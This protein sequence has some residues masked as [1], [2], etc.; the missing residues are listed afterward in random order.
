MTIAFDATST[1]TAASTTLTV[2][3]TCSGSDR[4][5]VVGVVG[6]TADE[7]T[8]VTYNGVAMT[9]I[10]KKAET[11]SRYVYLYYLNAPATG[12]HDIVVSA[13]GSAYLELSAASYTGVLQTGQPEVNAVNS[14]VS[15][16]SLTTSLTTLADNA[17]T[18][19]AALHQS[20][21]LTAGSGSTQRNT[22]LVGAILD[23]N[24]PVTP[25]GSKSMAF[26]GANSSN[27]PACVM[28][29]LAPAV[30]ASSIVNKEFARR[31]LNRGLT[32]GL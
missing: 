22:T 1:G 17:W 4:A 16:S 5:L 32:R 8:G 21:T 3:H 10:G 24:G 6:R 7:V 9:Q 18:V 12:A 2:S 27:N 25:A 30:A 13:S 31:G 14:A 28:V 20:G 11:G 15:A 26:S 23:S 19:L 29:S